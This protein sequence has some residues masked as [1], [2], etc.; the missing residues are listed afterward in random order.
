MKLVNV[1]KTIPTGRRQRSSTTKFDSEAVKDPDRLAD[2]LDRATS[3]IDALEA[4]APL[5]AVEFDV[6]CP[7]GDE[8]E[9]HHGFTGSIRWY[10]TSWRR[11]TNAG[12]YE[13]TELVPTDSGTLTL[14]SGAAGQAVIRVESAQNPQSL[15]D[16]STAD[17]LSCC[18]EPE[19]VT[20]LITII[21]TSTG[22]ITA[23]ATTDSNG[24]D[25]DIIIFTGVAPDLKGMVPTATSKKI[26]LM[27]TGGPLRIFHQAAA[28]TGVNRLITGPNAGTRTLKDEETSTVIYDTNLSKWRVHRGVDGDEVV[29]TAQTSLGN[30]DI[31][32]AHNVKIFG[33]TGSSGAASQGSMEFGPQSSTSGTVKL[34]PADAVSFRNGALNDDVGGLYLDSSNR[35]SIGEVSGSDNFKI[36]AT[37]GGTEALIQTTVGMRVV[38]GGVVTAG[39]DGLFNLAGLL[40]GG[41]GES[42]PFRVAHTSISLGGVAGTNVTES[43]NQY[44]CPLQL[45][46]AGA[47]GQ[48]VT[49]PPT[50]GSIYIMRV[51]G[52]FPA[53]IKASGQTG[54]TVESGYSALVRGNGTDIER[55]SADHN[56][57][58]ASTFIGGWQTIYDIDFTTLGL[59]TVAADGNFTIDGKTWTV[60]QW[61][62]RA[63]VMSVGGADGLRIKCNTSTSN[64]TVGTNSAPRF[65]SPPLTT[66][67]PTLPDEVRVGLRFSFYMSNFTRPGSGDATY[68]IISDST[69]DGTRFEMEQFNN[70]GAT[71]DYMRLVLTSSTKVNQIIGPILTTGGNHNCMQWEMNQLGIDIPNII[72]TGVYSSGWPSKWY[73]RAQCSAAAGTYYNTSIKELADARIVIAQN[74]VSVA[75]TSECKIGRMKIEYYRYQ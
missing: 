22:D 75:G 3:R 33:G 5:P 65:M 39:G 37:G 27:P 41:G 46:A 71:S 43:G 32:G 45:I 56:Y 14:Y 1:D 10:V 4:S 11:N 31:Q 64:M 15:R 26:T 52:G 16:T 68:F 55:I 60:A 19:P 34:G 17:P 59:S 62:A 9:I 67:L 70:A 44:E 21:N 73:R 38:C 25:A 57:A 23:C 30:G 49:V 61:A 36:G 72:H 66:L 13:L 24:D 50:Q 2:L 20:S 47:A 12:P 40:A 58:V 7:D 53:T 29:N 35:V 51:S 8:I 54:V 69:I 42:K 63:S 6:N 28:A 18:D 48:S 74:A